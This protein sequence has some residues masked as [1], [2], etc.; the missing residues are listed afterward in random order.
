M[1]LTA[2][3]IKKNTDWLLANA[4]PPVQ[5]LTHIHL[6]G[7]DPDSRAAMKLWQAVEQSEIVQDLF[8]KQHPDGSWFDNMP[9]ARKPAYIPQAGYSPFTPKYVTTIW[10]LSILGEMGFR[11]GDPHI[12]RACKYVLDHQLPNGL[13]HRFAKSETIPVWGMKSASELESAPCELSVYLGALTRLGMGSD[14]R[15]T[16]SF[17]LL[18]AW[19]RED[20]GWV[21]Q[22]HLEERFKTRSCPS[23]SH[24]A[25][26]ALYQ[27]GHREYEP[28]LRKAFSFLI[29]H[30]TLKDPHE[31]CRFIFRGHN[32]LQEML[33]FSDLGVGLDTQPVQKY[34]EWLLSLY[35]PQRGCFHYSG[36]MQD[37]TDLDPGGAKYGLFQLIDDEWLTYRITRIA[38]N[39]LRSNSTPERLRGAI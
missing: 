22:K 30:L 14:P 13:F 33:M 10:I 29:G 6:L 2:E 34:L 5:Y 18:V 21:L 27:S 38:A 9:W 24:G 36:S 11:V 32:L 3:Q 37:A 19:Q 8:A 1:F 12:D 16:K 15:L 17:D 4:S 25:A 35:N 26:V 23:S 7:L 20:G 31:M 39:L 28:A